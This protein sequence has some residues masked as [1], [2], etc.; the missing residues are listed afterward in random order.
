MV[1]NER[2]EIL[3]RQDDPNRDSPLD[4]LD[5]IPVELPPLSADICRQIVRERLTGTEFQV[6]QFE[7]LFTEPRQP[8]ELLGLCAVNYEKLHRGVR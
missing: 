3:F 1:S 5:P 6:S 7:P 4:G 8:K 2:L